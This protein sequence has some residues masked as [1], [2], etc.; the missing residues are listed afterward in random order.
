MSVIT[1]HS[2]LWTTNQIPNDYQQ[3]PGIAAGKQCWWDCMV[4]SELGRAIISVYDYK[5]FWTNNQ[6]TNRDQALPLLVG[7]HGT[8]RAIISI[9][10]YKA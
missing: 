2:R 7:L 3:R 1:K 6:I 10:D 5:L 4:L 9:Y 8:L